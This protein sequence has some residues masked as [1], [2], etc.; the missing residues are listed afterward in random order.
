MIHSVFHMFHMVFQQSSS[1]VVLGA[2]S[3]RRP[4]CPA[5]RGMGWSGWG[6][7]W[8]WVWVLCTW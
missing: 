7:P 6:W 1:D 2:D 4:L 8:L 3:P 5:D